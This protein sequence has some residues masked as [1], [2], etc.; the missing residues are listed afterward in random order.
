MVFALAGLTCF[1]VT[2][3]AS[4]QDGKAGLIYINPVQFVLGGIDV[5]VDLAVTDSLSVGPR[6]ASID[7]KSK[8]V[9]GPEVHYAGTS[10]GAE[11]NWQLG[12]EKS[13]GKGWVFSALVLYS[14]KYTATMTGPILGLSP[15][16]YTYESSYFIG[17]AF[18]G[19]RWIWGGLTLKLAGG[20]AYN[21]LPKDIV[22]KDDSG[23]T[24]SLDN[25][26][27]GVIPAAEILLGWA[28]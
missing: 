9:F 17:S 21:S 28:F 19:Y 26:S 3:R 10:F 22:M 11:A 2:S 15:S 23:N 14:P 16:I 18:V 12:S 8:S 27:S 7:L 25:K 13:I 5:G 6:L 4:A 1:L 24:A 20:V